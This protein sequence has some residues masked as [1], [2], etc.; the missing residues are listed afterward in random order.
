VTTNPNKVVESAPRRAAAS[1]RAPKSAPAEKKPAR[2]PLPVLDSP[3]PPV[4]ARTRADRPAELLHRAL[5]YVDSVDGA[6][7]HLAGGSP[8]F[9]RVD[10]RLAPIPTL[11]DWEGA[12]V[13]AWD[14]ATVE[15][16]LRSMTTDEQWAA[17]ERELESNFA[18]ELD[19]MRFRVNLYRQRGSVAAAMRRIPPRIRSLTEL[20]LPSVLA[21]LADLPRGLVLVTGRAGAGKSSTLAA[22]VDQVNRTR[23]AHIVTVEDPIEFVHTPHRS[24]VSQREVGVDTADYRTALAQVLRQDPDVILLGELRDAATISAA[25]TAAETGHLV[26]ATLHTQSAPQTID[27]IVDVFPGPHQD[28]VRA[29]LALTLKAVVAQDLIPRASGLGRVVAAEVLLSTPAIANL[30]REEKHHQLPTALMSGGA[31][32][33]QTMDQALAALVLAGTVSMECAVGVAHDRAQLAALLS[34]PGASW[35]SSPGAPPADLP[36]SA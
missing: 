1:T 15:T 5:R 6:D 8:P 24:L 32:G 20:G 35:R 3:T 22:L 30:I 7:L 28:Q 31:L 33:M 9:A 26:L 12:T 16:A 21:Q 27:R 14:E 23:S 10:G 25:L 36:R 18:L 34:Q 2:A 29:Q 13:G 11:S 17:F 19:G 4:P